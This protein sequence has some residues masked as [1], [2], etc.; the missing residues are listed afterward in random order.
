MNIPDASGHLDQ[1]LRQTRQHH[2]QLSAMAD[3]KANILL[4][5]S[6]L[7]ITFGIGYLSDP[8]LRWPVLVLILFCLATIVSAAYAVMPKLNFT[9]QNEPQSGQNILFFGNFMHLSYPDYLEAMEKVMHTPGAAY[10]AQVR[11]VY[12]LGLFLGH[13]KYR[14]IRLAY[15]CFISGL[16]LAGIV[17]VIV[18][19]ALLVG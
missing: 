8:V 9:R 15:L 12:E 19:M 17:F 4:T 5:L 7:I 1:M 13:K 2:V 11:E 18:E 14:F 3:V 16:F 6:S 10:E